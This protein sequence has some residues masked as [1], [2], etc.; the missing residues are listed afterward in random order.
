MKTKLLVTL[1][2]VA[3]ALWSCNARLTI[4]MKILDKTYLLNNPAYW[5]ERVK[6]LEQ[7]IRQNLL[8]N[9]YK[10]LEK[11]ILAETSKSMNSITAKREQQR[12]ER[13][14]QLGKESKEYSLKIDKLKINLRTQDSLI[15][16][17]SK[18]TKKVAGLKNEKEILQYQ[19]DTLTQS[20]LT[21]AQLIKDG[22]DAIQ[23]EKQTF[24]RIHENAKSTINAQIDSII[25]IHTRALAAFDR[26]WTAPSCPDTKTGKLDSCQRQSA[27][28]Q[29]YSLSFE[30]ATNGFI[31]LNKLG[32][33][34]K[35]DLMALSDLLSA[36]E[37]FDFKTLDDIIRQVV[38]FIE[39]E[40][41]PLTEIK[42]KRSVQNDPLASFV[43]G[44]GDQYWKAKMNEASAYTRI[45]NS[46]IAIVT[47]PNGEYTVKG[48]RNDASNATKA[49]FSFMS[50]TIEVLSNYAGFGF[51]SSPD[52]S[53]SEQAAVSMSGSMI[54][55]GSNL[56]RL[57]K[58]SEYARELI[59]YTILNEESNLNDSLKRKEAIEN[60]RNIF[61]ANKKLLLNE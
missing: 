32:N 6:P 48:V 31:E 4:D 3:L 19:M 27:A 29:D 30:L 26:A 55:A 2:P 22:K 11:S 13:I 37:T 38:T 34:V 17:Q 52:S 60:I 54:Q 21:K 20:W 57:K 1:M 56:N 33:T 51:S 47:Q 59:Y 50:S 36:D 46:D 18:D 53:E 45:G 42:E 44:A 40:V 15:T 43:A 39:E 7:K 24:R 5:L 61:N 23:M 49:T 16:A 25:Q 10:E 28:I 9:R 14:D 12:R 8:N 35:K 41:Q 58:N